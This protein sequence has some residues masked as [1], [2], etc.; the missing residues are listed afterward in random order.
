MG[1]QSNPV[2]RLT[3]LWFEIEGVNPSRQA[4]GFIGKL[5]KL[6]G[7]EVLL[8]AM[9]LIKSRPSQAKN[10]KNP[11]QYL[12]GVC[13]NIVMKNPAPTSKGRET[14]ENLMKELL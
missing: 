14:F 6:Y 5:Y 10:L 8:Q 9:D 11:N 2:T 1:H 7:E 12:R 13:R 3:K 4:F